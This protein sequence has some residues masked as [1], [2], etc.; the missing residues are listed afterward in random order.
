MSDQ[1]NRKRSVSIAGHRTSFSLEDRFWTCLRRMA[2]ERG[3]PV[4]ALVAEIDA[5]RTGD[6]NLSSMIRLRVLD[7]ALSHRE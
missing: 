4:A 6:G 3:M 2:A 7:W 5:G 1:Q